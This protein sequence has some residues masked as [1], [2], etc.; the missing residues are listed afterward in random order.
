MVSDEAK[1]L[2]DL[3]WAAF[4]D[5]APGRPA[6]AFTIAAVMLIAAVTLYC[7]PLDPGSLLERL[8]MSIAAAG[9][10]ALAV[11]L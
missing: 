10:I 11:G 1:T 6:I 9:F 2:G 7:S 4:F 8:R 3:L 5:H